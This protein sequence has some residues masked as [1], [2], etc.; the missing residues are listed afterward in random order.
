M[1]SIVLAPKRFSLQAEAKEIERADAVKAAE[2]VSLGVNIE[3]YCKIFVWMFDNIFAPDFL[4]RWIQPG[5]TGDVAVSLMCTYM[6]AVSLS[7]NLPTATLRCVP[8]C[9][10]NW[11]LVSS[12]LSIDI[13]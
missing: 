5:T 2:A 11:Q 9:A 13:V 1:M 10:F 12:W 3:R 7:A 8:A 6:Y 4:D